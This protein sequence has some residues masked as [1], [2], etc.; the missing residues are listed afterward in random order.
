MLFPGLG[1]VPESEVPRPLE[2]GCTRALMLPC[3]AAPPLLRSLPAAV[4]TQRVGQSEGPHPGTGAQRRSSAVPASLALL[5]GKGLRGKGLPLLCGGS[6]GRV[7]AYSSCL[8]EAAPAPSPR[9]SAWCLCLEPGPWS[10]HR[11]TLRGGGCSIPG[12]TADFQI[13][14]CRVARGISTNRGWGKPAFLG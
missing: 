6:P 12:N 2:S 1:S 8:L 5:G 7:T 11:A 10:A 9:G 13:L 3:S 4:R 14:P